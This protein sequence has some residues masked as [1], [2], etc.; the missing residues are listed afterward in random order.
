M[1]TY[2]RGRG[3]MNNGMIDTLTHSEPVVAVTLPEAI[4]KIGLL[5][6]PRRG[7]ANVARLL[8]DRSRIVWIRPIYEYAILN[9]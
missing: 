5:R 6:M 3:D 1:F 2:Q 9:G 7:R 4:E 8:D